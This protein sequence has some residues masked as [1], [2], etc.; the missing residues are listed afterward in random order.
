VAWGKAFAAYGVWVAAHAIAGLVFALFVG[1][2]PVTSWWIVLLDGVAAGAIFGPVQWLVLRRFVRPMKL[3]APAT[4]AASPVSWAIGIAYGTATFSL[5]GWFGAGFSAA[6]QT[7][8]LLATFGRYSRMTIA[9]AMWF[10]AAIFGGAI[11]YFSYLVSVMFSDPSRPPPLPSLV[12]GS[13]G[14]AVVTG[15]VVA[16]LAGLVDSPQERQHALHQ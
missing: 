3:W 5:G 7:A 2:V 1:V 13:V 12:V 14:F 6:V 15:L 11:F 8:I 16:V 4:V 10:P 9:S